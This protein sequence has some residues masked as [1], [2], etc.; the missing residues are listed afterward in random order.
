MHEAKS[1]RVFRWVVIVVLG[2]FTVV[3]LYVMVTSSLKPLGDVQGDFHW[4]PTHLTIQPFIDIWSTV[5]LAR[6]F[7]NSLVVCTVATVFSVPTSI[8]ETVPSAGLLTK[9]SRSP[10][11]SA[12]S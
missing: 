9:A 2:A 4:L 10:L 12:M 5:P 11:P 6:Y 3:P 7:A 8:T 1:F